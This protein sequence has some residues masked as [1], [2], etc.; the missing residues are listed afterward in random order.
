MDYFIY[1]LVL[2]IIDL[3]FDSEVNLANLVVENPSQDD[4]PSNGGGTS[5]SPSPSRLE[6]NVT[7]RK[8][9]PSYMMS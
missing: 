5:F 1:R 9:R 4:G 3:V 8:T 7:V 2:C 6:K